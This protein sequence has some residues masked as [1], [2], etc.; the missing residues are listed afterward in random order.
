MNETRKGFGAIRRRESPRGR[1][2]VMAES[3]M[4]APQTPA[5]EQALEEELGT[6]TGRLTSDLTLS[7][8][9]RQR[10]HIRRAA[11]LEWRRRHE[12]PVESHAT[13]KLHA[14]ESLQDIPDLSLDDSITY[15][16]FGEPLGPLQQRRAEERRMRNAKD[17][18]EWRTTGARLQ[19]SGK[20]DNATWPGLAAK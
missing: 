17:D 14:P 11:I 12:V 6:L 16:V 5:E 9:E 4:I 10:L 20:D 13:P 1:D 19:A 8:D 18:A 15:P 2:A 3:V 7:D